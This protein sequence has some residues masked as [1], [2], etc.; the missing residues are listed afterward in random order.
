MRTQ[1]LHRR[2]FTLLF[3]LVCSA[4]ATPPRVDSLESRYERCIAT[5]GGKRYESA[6]GAAFWG[7]AA[8]MQTC[9]PP[10]SPLA[11][12]FDIFIAIGADGAM[13]DLTFEPETD[14]ARCIKARVKER[15]FEPPPVPG[16]VIKIEL[17][18]T[19]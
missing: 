2:L 7:D 8:F 17:K 6:V 13:T 1:T 12:P 19:E 3:A 16:C 10:G 4:G 9:V 15:H 18:F 14:A 5:P 11:Q